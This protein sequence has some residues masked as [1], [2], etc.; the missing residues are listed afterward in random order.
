MS[1]SCCCQGNSCS[2]ST[3]KDEVPVV[4][5]KLTF[6]DTLGSW[7]VRWGIG[8]MTYTV[9][10]G[11]YAVG[12]PDSDSYVFVSANYKMSFDELRKNLDG[13]D[14]WI[15]VLDTRGVN[16][17]CAAGKGTFGTDEL[18]QR[19]E[20]TGLSEIVTRRKLILPQLGASGVCAHEVWQRSGFSV[21]FGP[22]RA[23]DIKAFITASLKATKEMREVTFPLR[24]R[25]AVTPMELLPALRRTLPVFGVV[26]L[27]NF[28]ARRPFGLFDALAYIGAIMVGSV[29]TPILLP[30]IPV[31]A[32]SLKGWLLGIVFT[33]IAL[34]CFGYFSPGYWLLT[35]GYCLLLPAISAY[36]A[37]NFTG[38]STYP[39][40]S[41]VQK[42][43][44]RSLPFIL[45]GVVAGGILILIH[46]LF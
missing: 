31:R 5:T 7:K 26:F 22:V 37:L 23:S 39:S 34:L 15:L 45:G 6:Q 40:P 18:V 19:I 38:A 30:F 14:C 9:D 28:I 8:R 13:L 42:E 2:C 43:M 3:G 36:L 33:V 29:V 17:W 21:V 20:D 10:P 24:D 16:V 27:L 11:L 25:L 12:K 41:G 4:S 35:I 32:F 46:K 44:K 1:Q